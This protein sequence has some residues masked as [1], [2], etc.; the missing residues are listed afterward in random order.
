MTAHNQLIQ[1]GFRVIDLEDGGRIYLKQDLEISITNSFIVS[2]HTED[3]SQPIPQEITKLAHELRSQLK[4][5]RLQTARA[6]DKK[7]R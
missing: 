1:L 3:M 7:R 5:F 2:I 6:T 4:E